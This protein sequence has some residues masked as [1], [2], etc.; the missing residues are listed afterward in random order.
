MGLMMEKLVTYGERLEWAIAKR[1][2]SAAEISKKTKISKSSLSQY[3][4]GSTGAP[5]NTTSAKLANFLNINQYWLDTGQGD[6][7]VADTNPEPQNE[8][9]TSLLASSSPS[10]IGLMENLRD[11]EKNQKLTPEL[12]SLLNA[13]IDT[14]RKVDT[15][16]TMQ[17]DIDNLVKI[18]EEDSR[19]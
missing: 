19:E 15:T 14:F 1:E 17:V 4:S 18:S 11:M 5:R 6:W 8:S 13:T 7:R 2:T 16:Q 10:V 12:V 3:I 9:V